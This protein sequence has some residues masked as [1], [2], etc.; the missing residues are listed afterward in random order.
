M[1]YIVCNN[2]LLEISAAFRQ[3]DLVDLKFTMIYFDD[4]ISK[5]V[6][7]GLEMH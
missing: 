3:N 1:L 5:F 6:L 2:P 4:C 7:T